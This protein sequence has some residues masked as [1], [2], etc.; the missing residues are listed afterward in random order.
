MTPVWM[1]PLRLRERDRAWT[2]Y[3]LDPDTTYVNFGFWGAVARRPGS[4]RATAT[5]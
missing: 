4:K 1:C 2:L 3:P 5:A